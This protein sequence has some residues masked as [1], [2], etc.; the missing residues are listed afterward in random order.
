[1]VNMLSGWTPYD[2]NASCQK[3]SSSRTC[4]QP[5]VLSSS[6]SAVQYHSQFVDHQVDQSCGVNLS[7]EDWGG[8]SVLGKCFLCISTWNPHLGISWKQSTITARLTISV[9]QSFARNMVLNVLLQVGNAKTCFTHVWLYM[10]TKRD[11]DYV[12]CAHL[13]TFITSTQSHLCYIISI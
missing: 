7:V 2:W 8:I 13:L 11:T 1:M 10:T 12:L 6:P 9:T 4:V 3:V 5:C